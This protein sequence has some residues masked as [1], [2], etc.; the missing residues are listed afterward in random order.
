MASPPA[1]AVRVALTAVT[2]LRCAD[3]ADGAA[4]RRRSCAALTAPMVLRCAD[5]ADGAALF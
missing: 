3:R 4:L 2:V 5:R 1:R